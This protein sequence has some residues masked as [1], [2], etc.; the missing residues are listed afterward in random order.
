M[1]LFSK[2]TEKRMAAYQQELLKT[3][4]REVETMYRE[5]RGWRHDFRNHIQLLQTYAQKGDL[6]AI[7]SYLTEL[8]GDLK[9]VEPAVKTGNS[10]ADAILNSGRFGDLPGQYPVK[11]KR[12]LQEAKDEMN[13]SAGDQARYADTLDRLRQLVNEVADSV[14]HPSLEE[15]LQICNDALEKAKGAQ[16]Q[17]GGY[18][19]Q[20]IS[21]FEAAIN[22]VQEKAKSAQGVGEKYA[23]VLELEDA[24]IALEEGKY[25]ADILDITAPGL[26]SA[27]VDDEA[28]EVLLRFPY[29]MPLSSVTLA[30]ELKGNAKLGKSLSQLDLTH[31]QVI[32]VYCPE[33]RAY[34]NWTIRATYEAPQPQESVEGWSNY[35][36]SENY[37]FPKEDGGVYLAPSLY[38]AMNASPAGNTVSLS[39]LPRQEKGETAITVLFGAGSGEEMEIFSSHAKNDRYELI[40]EKGTVSLQSVTE[41]TKQ[42]VA[43]GKASLSFERAN[44]LQIH[45]LPAGEKDTR[46]EVFLDGRKVLSEIAPRKA[47]EGYYGVYSPNVGVTVY[48]NG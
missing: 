9:R 23:L 42:L 12:M 48:N 33:K 41:G 34:Q 32:P 16:E 36:S 37:I 8:E 30:A 19:L 38:P 40:F 4:Y 13:S 21:D 31:D 27:Q 26:I 3:H 24:Y 17:L 44:E 45:M 2:K 14:K 5:M 6:E 43:S 28:K 25:S 11:Y 47:I 10:M 35:L 15:M 18:P 46:I 20:K 22:A 29:N 39:F 1:G 7:K